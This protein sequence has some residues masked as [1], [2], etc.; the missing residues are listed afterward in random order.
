MR[1][2]NVESAEV[3]RQSLQTLTAVADTIRVQ[4]RERRAHRPDHPEKGRGGTSGSRDRPLRLSVMNEAHRILRPGGWFIFDMKNVARPAPMARRGEGTE[5]RRAAPNRPH[6]VLH[7]HPVIEIRRRCA[8]GQLPGIV[9]SQA[10]AL[11]RVRTS[12]IS[13]SRKSS[14]GW[15]GSVRT[16]ISCGNR[17]GSVR[18]AWSTLEM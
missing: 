16:S 4:A 9:P 11:A 18:Y 6:E 17:S 14:P 8:S 10:R 5:F 2:D 12:L 13:V 1:M 7:R 3:H 15:P